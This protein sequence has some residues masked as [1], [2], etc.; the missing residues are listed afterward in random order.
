MQVTLDLLEGSGHAGRILDLTRLD[1][2][3]PWM[4]A[5]CAAHGPLDGLA[6]CAGIQ[7]MRPLQTASL[8]YIH[9]VINANPQRGAHPGPGLPAEALP[10]PGGVAGLRRLDGGNQGRSRQY[11]LFRQQGRADRGGTIAGLE[12]L[13]DG[14]RVNAVAPALV[15][16][17]I[18]QSY[19]AVTEAGY[20]NLVNQQPLGIGHPDDVAA[21]IAFLMAGTSKWITGT[22]LNVDGGFLA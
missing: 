6:H 1:A 16:T 13:R 18:A 15:D 4:K 7:S 9:E 3:T 10:C 2:I 14:I 19:R 8:A 17:P 20:Q 12:L 22:V 21:A 11:G 5:L